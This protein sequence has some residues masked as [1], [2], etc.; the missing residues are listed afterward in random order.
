[1]RS[2]SNSVLPRRRPAPPPDAGLLAVALL[3]LANSAAA[4]TVSVTIR[5][6][7][8]QPAEITVRAGDSVRWINDEKRQY[9]NVWFEQSGEPEPPYLFPEETYERAFPKAGTFPYRCGPHPE[10]TGVVQVTE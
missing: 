8:Y 5:E 4:E 3:M 9:H 2:G 1:M 10:M 7:R 6:Y